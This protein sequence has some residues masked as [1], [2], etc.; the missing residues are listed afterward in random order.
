LIFKDGQSKDF[1]FLVIKD[2]FKHNL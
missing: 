1:L 2:N